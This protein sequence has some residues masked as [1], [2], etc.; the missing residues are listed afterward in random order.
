MKLPMSISRQGDRAMMVLRT[1]TDP[2]ADLLAALA[3][4]KPP[5][6]EVHAVSLPPIEGR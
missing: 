2:P 4:A 6:R 1:D 5:I 3:A